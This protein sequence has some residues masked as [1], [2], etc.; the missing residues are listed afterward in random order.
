MKRKKAEPTDRS[1]GGFSCFGILYYSIAPYIGKYGGG[2]CRIC[3]NFEIYRYKFVI[4]APK[5][6]IRHELQARA[7]CDFY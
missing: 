7:G 3:F 2:N 5:A 6:K 4:S 1:M